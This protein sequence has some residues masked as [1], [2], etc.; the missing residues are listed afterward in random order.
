MLVN[1]LIKYCLF[2]I[3]VGSKCSSL[4]FIYFGQAKMFSVKAMTRYDINFETN[5][6]TEKAD[7]LFYCAS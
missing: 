6:T 5:C 3:L 1:M 4:Y 7:K 2:K